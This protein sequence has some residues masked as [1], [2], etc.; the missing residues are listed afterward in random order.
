MVRSSSIVGRTQSASFSE[1]KG[2]TLSIQAASLDDFTPSYMY[3]VHQAEHG[4][5]GSK[6]ELV[7]LPEGT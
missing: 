6:Y 5:E 3:V 2:G 1:L 7:T 4:P